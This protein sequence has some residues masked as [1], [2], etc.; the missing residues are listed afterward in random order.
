MIGPETNAVIPAITELLKDKEWEVRN[1]AAFAL[2][3]LGNQSNV[4]TAVRL[5]TESLKDRD[6]RVREDAA[7]NLGCIGPA[8]R[9]AVPAL[10]ELLKDKVKLV[11]ESAA[12]ALGRIG[13]EA[14]TAIPAITETIKKN[15]M[16]HWIAADA[17]GQ[18]GPAAFPALTELLKDKSE[19]ARAAAATALG[20]A[21][22]ETAI[23]ALAELLKDHSE[24]VREHAAYALGY[25]GPEAKMVIPTLTELLKDKNG[26]VRG[27]AASALGE[28]GPDAKIA[29][30]PLTELLDD[31]SEDV[32]RNATSALRHISPKAVAIPALIKL[33]KDKDWTVREAAAAT[34][35]QVGPTVIP[36]IVDLLKDQSKD[37]R[38]GAAQALGYIGPAAK[39]AIP[40]LTELL[41]DKDEGVKATTAWALERIG[42]EATTAIPSLIA[43]LKDRDARVRGAAAK[44]LETIN[45]LPPTPFA[46]SG[47]Q[48]EKEEINSILPPAPKDQ[49][50][51]LVWHDE[52]DGTT[53]DT[54]KWEIMPD[55]P[56]KGGFWSPKAVS[57]DGKG[58]LVISTIKE[59]DKFIDGCVRTKGKF[60]HSF[61]YYVARV[62]LQKQPGHW[63]AFW[64]MGD[65]VG[66]VGSG[67]R[68]GTEIDI[69]E[70]P[71]LDDRVQHTLHWDGYG[72]DH[73][74]EGHVAKVTGIM[75]GWHT[76]GLWWK[77]DEYIFYVD[78]KETWRTKGA[79]Q[80]PEYMKLSDEIGNWGGDIKTAK[81]PD[82]F[83]V[84]YVRVYDVVE[85]K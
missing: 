16:V 33:L 85:M 75:D 77:P 21:K 84:D 69:Y 54:A 28:F 23:P 59:G 19:F 71:W 37:V 46:S 42:P 25:I 63:S 2:G 57:L 32:R 83:L 79:C 18:I 81:L 72:K 29:I 40:A 68:D 31:K 48:P 26:A 58:H 36:P 8:A 76:F 67:G 10:T 53:L 51:V 65:G 6:E 44:A 9:T 35:A 60:E 15:Q 17:L 3:S 82:A 43:L 64:I 38:W 22:V 1:S 5:V 24:L 66:K 20:K 7:Y 39:I 4:E 34:A 47:F 30:M 50:W 41:K 61:G 73:K 74:S 11:R 27:A 62:Q 70:K 78:G 49:T 14:K 45:R 80:V 52:F 55:A 12:Q 56:R 13:P